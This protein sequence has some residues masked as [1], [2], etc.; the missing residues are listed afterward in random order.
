MT[1]FLFAGI[2]FW[3]CA[4]EAVYCLRPRSRVHTATMETFDRRKLA[5]MLAVIL[6]CTLPM[7]LSPYWNGEI[8][9]YNNQYETI[10][11]AF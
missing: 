11:E 10:T 4:V 2:A 6:L 8:L 7:S 3:A 1:I 5:V 9:L